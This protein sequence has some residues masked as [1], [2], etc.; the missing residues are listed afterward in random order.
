[1][2]MSRRAVVIGVGTDV[3]LQWSLMGVARAAPDPDEW[4][5]NDPDHDP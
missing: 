2:W 4:S 1:M 3:W 5:T